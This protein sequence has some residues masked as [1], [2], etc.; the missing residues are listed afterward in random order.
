LTERGSFSLSEQEEQ[1]KGWT[2]MQTNSEQ[3][4]DYFYIYLKYDERGWG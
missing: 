4:D 2:N 3:K 1:R